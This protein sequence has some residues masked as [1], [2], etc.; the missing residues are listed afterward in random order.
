MANHSPTPWLYENGQV[1]DARGEL[2]AT[3]A[4][5]DNTEANGALIEHVTRAI[6]ILLRA[7]EEIILLENADDGS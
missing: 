3:M 2:V 4:I 7:C 1:F 6:S 5:G